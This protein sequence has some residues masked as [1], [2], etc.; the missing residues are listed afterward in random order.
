MCH[1]ILRTPPAAFVYQDNDNT[2]VFASPGK[3]VYRIQNRIKSYRDPNGYLRFIDGDKLV[4]R[5]LAEKK[6]SRKLLPWEV[7]HHID[8]DKLN[9]SLNNLLICSWEEHELIHRTN[10]LI[11]NNWHKPK[12]W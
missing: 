12:G 5:Y 8:G 6:L 2:N 9:N 4:H 10:Q 11:Y 7:V 1:I 3:T